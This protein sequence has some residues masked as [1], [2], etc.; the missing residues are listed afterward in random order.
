[1]LG[2]SGF[3]L[4]L[5]ALTMA[6]VDVYPGMPALPTLPQLKI[7]ILSLSVA[8]FGSLV[9]GYLITRFLPKTP[10]YHA[11]VSQTASGVTSDIALT[12]KHNKRLGNVGTTVSVLRPGGKAHFGDQIIDVI[13]QGEMIGKGR[14][15]RI[16]GNSTHAAIVEL[17]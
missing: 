13:S 7:P 16:I 11:L 5:V 8:I 4:I 14:Q 12:E 15:V 9:M 3:L 10:L 17:V 6:M 2:L 1:M